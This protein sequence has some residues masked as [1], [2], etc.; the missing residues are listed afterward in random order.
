MHIN[1]QPRLCYIQTKKITYM[2]SKSSK[3]LLNKELGLLYEKEYYYNFGRAPN[4][5]SYL[6]NKRNNK[7]I[8]EKKLHFQ[9]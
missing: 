3:W 7:I 2:D 4:N 1:V 8:K 5:M 6:N 9:R